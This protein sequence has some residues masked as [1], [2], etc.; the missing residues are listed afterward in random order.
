M[1]FNAS[2]RCLRSFL[3]LFA[4]LALTACVEAETGLPCSPDPVCPDG[5]PC[6]NMCLES[7]TE[8]CVTGSSRPCGPEVQGACRQGTQVCINGKYET[9]CTG[10]V[11][12][13]SE[14]CNGLDDDCDGLVD[15]ELGQTYFIDIDQ[16]GFGSGA[17]GAEAQIACAQP[18]GFAANSNDCDDLR[19]AVNASAPEVCDAMGLD[20]NCNGT[21]NEGCQCTSLGQTQA[22]CAGRGV[23]TCAA[24]DGGVALSECSLATTPEIC[25]G[26]DDDCDGMVDDGVTLTCLKDTDNDLYADDATTV[27]RQ[28]PDTSR[29]AAGNCPRGFI[30]ANKSLGLD[31]SPNDG[32]RYV[33]TP[34]QRDEDNDGVCGNTVVS[35]CL[36]QGTLP[37]AGWRL[38]STC[39]SASTDC[40]DTNSSQSFLMNVRVDA[41]GDGYCSGAPSSTCGGTV[42]A[43]GLRS[44]PSCTPTDDCDDNSSARFLNHTVR[45]DADADSYCAGPTQT[46]CGG[47]TP[48]SGHRLANA[49][50]NADDCKDDNRFANLRCSTLFLTAPTVK[51]CGLGHPP[52]QRLPASTIMP[53][54]TGF[55]VRTTP[56]RML[57][58]EGGSC[59]ATSQ[60]EIEFQCQSL[61]FGR[62]ECEI[63]SECIAN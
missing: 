33:L 46:Q 14:T 34:T 58:T 32:L 53:C 39:L 16:D 29:P 56:T 36:G 49:C 19:S 30:S 24:T 63:R 1:H 11:T 2:F 28:C 21:V 44:T 57:S 60:W 62:I 6:T 51:Q 31:C 41:D 3:P 59:Q 13:S 23:Q 15:E 47:A 25:N 20:E 22:C 8:G 52:V 27:V 17:A 55:S 43:V 4:L 48:P 38:P 26:V 18:S 61:I 45:R 42:A 54:P 7:V 35:H 50:Q 10:A 37:P 12:A 5:G 40:N 9:E